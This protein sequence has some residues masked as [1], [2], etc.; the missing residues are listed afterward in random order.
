MQN[1][2]KLSSGKQS[3]H[4]G[5]KVEP[6]TGKWMARIYKDKKCHYLGLFTRED[7]AAKAYNIKAIE[8]YG[9]NAKLN[10]T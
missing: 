8:L 7:E 4:V 9:K 3:K 2:S 6:D 1:R 5:V 10:K